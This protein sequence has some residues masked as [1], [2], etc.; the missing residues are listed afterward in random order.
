MPKP[1][2][3]TGTYGARSPDE[4]FALLGGEPARLCDLVELRLDLLGTGPVPVE[5][6]VGAAPGD[7]IVTCRPVREGGAF[8]GSE[9]A[10]LA[11]LARAADAGAAWIDL[12]W[13]VSDAEL[14]RALREPRS[15]LRVI[16]SAHVERLSSDDEIA[17]W[18]SRLRAGGTVGKLIAAEGCAADA[19]RLMRAVRAAAGELV[20]HVVAQ[21]FS[22]FGGAA[23]G[24]PVTYVAL[25]PGG[26]LGLTLPTVAT[27]LDVYRFRRIRPGAALFLLLGRDVTGSVSP[28]MLDAAFAADEAESGAPRRVALPWSL[29]DPLPAI[30]AL[31]EFAWAGAAVTMP[32]KL[33]V[34]D[35]LAAGGGAL[36]ESA[37]EVGSVNTVIQ[38][39]GRL[40]GHNTDVAGVIGA[41]EPVAPEAFQHEAPA[42]V[43]GAGGAA[44]AAVVALRRLGLTPHIWARRAEARDALAE[45]TGAAAVATLDDAAALRPAL[46]IDAT[47]SG[48]PGEEPLIDPATLPE[49][50]VVLDMLV[51]ARETALVAAA[52]RVGRAAAPG[53]AMLIA[54]AREQ[55]SL[56]GASGAPQLAPAGHAALRR[57]AQNV[58]LLGLRWT[59][60]S[61]IATRLA[62]LL[63]RPL[64]DTDAEVSRRTGSTPEELIARG[65]ETRFRAVERA[66]LVDAAALPGRV[67]ACGGGVALH[68]D[69][70]TALGAVSIVCLLDAPDDVLLARRTASPRAPLTALSPQRELAAQR[71]AR[72]PIYAK[73]AGLSLDVSAS[74]PDELA[75]RLAEMIELRLARAAADV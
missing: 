8:P 25:R 46:V 32:H 22:R 14:P 13:D 35:W 6:L 29:D 24:A 28:C 33:T 5:T 68:E 67:I 7:V 43:L 64:L 30:E 20:A 50:A 11:L 49:R 56:L 60:K 10:R 16:R 51:S 41:L 63:G 36:G 52:R 73:L 62:A 39:D 65:E 37:V 47:P 15:G 57:R 26:N 4:L 40:D 42:V 34:H 44:L 59:G 70:L 12:E 23:L 31:S 1:S 69:A 45:R 75:E 71:A 21:P 66:V 55:L 18:A 61:T 17:A 38:R 3:L 19:V 74:L 2:L 9:E 54:Q 53:M 58:V 72:M 48:Q 27:A